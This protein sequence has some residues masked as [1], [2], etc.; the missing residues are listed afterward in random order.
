MTNTVTKR[1]RLALGGI[2]AA[3]LLAACSSTQQGAQ[4]AVSGSSSATTGPD[5][6]A[7]S[8]AQQQFA[9]TWN[10]AYTAVGMTPTVPQ[11]DA[12]PCQ[13]NTSKYAKAAPAGG[14]RIAFAS[15]GPTN[16]WAVTQ[17]QAFT[18][19]AA[20]LGVTEL[21]ASADGDATK[22]V[23]NLQQLTAQAPDAMV[24]V[25]MG[26][27]I[28]GQLQAAEAAGIPIVLCSGIVAN[29]GAVS[30]VTRS[31]NL[32][33]TLYADWIAKQIGSTGEVAMLS[34]I[35]GVP[36]AELEK[37]AAIREFA[38]FPNIK[39]VTKQYTDWSPTKAKTIAANM[40]V[41]Y[42]NL[43]AIWSDSANTNIGVVQAYQQAGKPVPPISGDS[44]NAFL[45]SIKGSAVQFISGQF[46]PEMS[47]TCLDTAVAILKGQSV[48][49]FI[50]VDAVTYTNAQQA[51]YIRPE[52]GDNLW[53]PSALP[54]AVLKSAKLC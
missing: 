22:Q 4:P 48:A 12:A 9:Q 25:P 49:S 5:C 23:N 19:E 20:K 45:K 43:K 53:V 34:G 35:A 26:D 16:S 42:P 18:V 37:V 47:M 27:G 7:T 31:Y 36:T 21:Y 52:C 17:E 1:R 41:Q 40:I 13:V 8:V 2:A 6:S 24:V 33:G 11:P 29:S 38:T 30:T 44:A 3:L 28:V 15:Q 54:D 10:A 14:Y 46:P 50:N 32:L 39:V 51:T